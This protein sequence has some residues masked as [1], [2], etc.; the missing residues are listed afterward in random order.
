M[1]HSRRAIVGLVAVFALVL[2]ACGDSGEDTTVP[3]ATDAPTTTVVATT[4]AP[5]TTTTAPVTTTMAPTTTTMAAEPLLIW[6]DERRVPAL[7]AVAP[8]FTEATGVEVVVE[9]VPFGEIRDQVR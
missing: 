6:A 4:M 3:P 7:Q 2:A 1:K 8:A 9:L 5:T